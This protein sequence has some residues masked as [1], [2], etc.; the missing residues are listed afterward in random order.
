MKYAEGNKVSFTC[1][2]NQMVNL[3][4]RR[5][6]KIKSEYHRGNPCRVSSNTLLKHSPSCCLTPVVHAFERD[7]SLPINYNSWEDKKDQLS[8]YCQLQE[9]ECL[10]FKPS[11]VNSLLELKATLL[12]GGE[13]R[14]TQYL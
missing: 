11:K 1:L 4:Q 7:S 10:A 5:N 8:L 12:K 13:Q 9:S 14:Q 2:R 6:E 3:R